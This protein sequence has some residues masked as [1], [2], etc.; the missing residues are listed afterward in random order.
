MSFLLATGG[1][2]AP[3]FYPAAGAQII[4]LGSILRLEQKQAV[5]PHTGALSQTIVGKTLAVSLEE[6]EF[7][8]GYP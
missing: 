7:G 3:E 1:T 8:D 5:S 2:F 4:K 6:K